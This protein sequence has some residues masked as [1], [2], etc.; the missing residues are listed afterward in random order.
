MAPIV[1]VI[2]DYDMLNILTKTLLLT[3]KSF[4]CGHETC[5]STLL[6]QDHQTI[7]PARMPCCNK[8]ALAV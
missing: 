5:V 3:S 4:C 8:Y 1:L 2:D 6:W 7:S